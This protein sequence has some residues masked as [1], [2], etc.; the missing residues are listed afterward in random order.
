M[1]VKV[2]VIKERF[3]MDN[4]EYMRFRM[5][6]EY[7]GIEEQ[8]PDTEEIQRHLF[9]SMEKVDLKPAIHL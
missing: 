8:E 5:M 4:F 1:K 2:K 6:H 7:E 9:K 3:G